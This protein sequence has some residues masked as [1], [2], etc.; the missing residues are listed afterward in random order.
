MKFSIITPVKNGQPY[1]AETIESV[2]N[3]RGDFD[4][5]YILVDGGSSDHTL[6]ICKHYQMQIEQKVRG[7]FC[8]NI[9][10]RIIQQSDDS[11]F[12]ALSNGFKVVS[13]DFIA[14][15]N[16]DD[17][18]LPN[19]FSCVADVFFKFSD[20][21]WLTGLPSRFNEKGQI[22]RTYFPFKYNTQ[23]ISKGFYGKAL[24]FIQQES[25]FWR[26]DLIKN[27]NLVE[28]KKYKLAGDFYLWHSFASEGFQLYILESVLS[29]NRIRQGQLSENRI[30]YFQEF[31]SIK[32]SSMVIDQFL[33]I[34][35]KL[36]EK[37]I[38]IP[39]KRKF[40]KKRVCFR[41]G[42]WQLL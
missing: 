21:F 8:K 9:E 40:S 28:L 20:I 18:Y 11:M 39:V 15:L 17:F 24:P 26:S 12:D 30:K 6:E 4:I 42:G 32:S 19:A 41:K 37:F 35:Y 34:I 14:Y 22:I 5:E 3:Q 36:I 1:I 27:I 2:L 31:D 23:L 25:V 38:G 29:G 33:V 7:I 13:G 16:S 10:V